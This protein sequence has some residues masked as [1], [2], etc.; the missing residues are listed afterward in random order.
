MSPYNNPSPP[1]VSYPPGPIA[2]SGKSYYNH[3]DDSRLRT[4]SPTPSEAKA[5]QTGAIDWRSMA[6]WR[7]WLRREWLWYYVA[8]VIILVV[9]ALVTLYHKQIVHWLTPVTRWL[10]DLPFGW[11]V[12]IGVL[13]VI[14]FPPLFGHE[15]VAIL[16]GLVWGLWVGFG[17][18]AA[19]TFLGE[20][21]NFYAFKYCCRARGEKMERTK[22]SY[23]CL[24]KVVRDGGF[25]I[26]LVAR[27]SAIPGHFTTAV[28][29]TCGMGIIVFSLA[30]ILSLPKQFITVYLGVIL[31]QS[32]SGTTDTKS[33]IIS[34]VVLAITFLITIAAMWYIVRQMNKVKPEV[35]YKRRRARLAKIK[36]Q[37]GFVP[38]SASLSSV[39][40]DREPLTTMQTPYQQFDRRGSTNNM[41]EVELFA[42]VPQRP[43]HH[44]VGFD[45]Y[46]AI[47]GQRSA[48]DEEEVEWDM[49]MRDAYDGIESSDERPITVSEDDRTPMRDGVDNKPINCTSNICVPSATESLCTTKAINEYE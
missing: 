28:F 42:P 23:A 25:K 11:L 9:T 22:I 44:V 21:G 24:A 35:I 34:D 13:F 18:V 49:S 26:A 47:D 17:I 48:R 14:S 32:E 40:S 36:A 4:P 30:A 20:I 45:G 46:H 37:N 16:C 43:A 39:D 27:L 31:E 1:H 10:H 7:F 41:S 6:N 3:S 19:G 15:I 8:L 33:R 12:P 38:D 2:G 29:S 5:M